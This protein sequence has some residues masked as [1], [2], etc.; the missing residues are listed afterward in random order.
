MF[1]YSDE[2]DQKRLEGR[3]N[4]DSRTWAQQLN[5]SKVLAQTLLRQPLFVYG[6]FLF[7]FTRSKSISKFKSFHTIKNCYVNNRGLREEKRA[8]KDIYFEWTEK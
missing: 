1:V 3:R 6:D 7:L 8:Q 4:P 5:M 2:L